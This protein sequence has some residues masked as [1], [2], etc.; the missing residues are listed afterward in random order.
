[1]TQAKYRQGLAAGS[2][3]PE[4]TWI[5]ESEQRILARAVW[6]GF[7]EDTHPRELDC[8]HVARSVGDPV[9]VCA[10]LVRKVIE[11][12]PPGCEHPSYQ[13]LLP[14]DWRSQESI[15]RAV[16]WRLEAVAR[17]GLA[18]VVERLRYEWTADLELRPRSTRLTF[19]EEPDDE[20]WADLFVR[21]A[22]G[23]LDAD[24]RRELSRVGSDRAAR[25]AVGTYKM[26]PGRRDWWR[27]AYSGAE[28][29]GFAIPSSNENGYIVA[30]LGVLPEH[31][32]NGYVHDILDEATHWFAGEGAPRIVADVDAAN[33]P[34]VAAFE[35]AG[36]RN[37]AVRLVAC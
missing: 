27:V 32:G 11:A 5:A 35:R 1:V 6:W 4:W 3:R 2:Y 19:V 13:V 20:V 36:Y 28:R 29:I 21:V 23:S 17:A 16:S 22:D 31:R 34:M 7:P 30:Y 9:G 25:N 26:L 33:V 10:E 8:L 15:A 37:F 24:T 12:A 18:E 14:C